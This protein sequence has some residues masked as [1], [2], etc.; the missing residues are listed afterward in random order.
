MET[1]MDRKI[2]G[3]EELRKMFNYLANRAERLARETE[4]AETEM[5]EAEASMYVRL[6]DALSAE[7]AFAQQIDSKYT[8]IK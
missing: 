8:N 2:A 1:G 6:V 5:Y 3:F 7:V 4:G